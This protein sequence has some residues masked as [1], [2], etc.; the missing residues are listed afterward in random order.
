MTNP[1]PTRV[2]RTRRAIRVFVVL[3]LACFVLVILAAHGD[4]VFKFGWP[5]WLGAGAGFLC[6]DRL[7]PGAEI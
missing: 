7:F 1:T 4:D 3:A 2:P 6:L 5:S